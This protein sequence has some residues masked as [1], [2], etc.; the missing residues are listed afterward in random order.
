MD[1]EHNSSGIEAVVKAVGT[2]LYTLFIPWR[3]NSSIVE[4]MSQDK[5]ET[6]MNVVKKWTESKSEELRYVGLAVSV[7]LFS[8][9]IMKDLTVLY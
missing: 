6:G 3:A 8:Y 9:F 7:I 4:E 5:S 1:L 2:G